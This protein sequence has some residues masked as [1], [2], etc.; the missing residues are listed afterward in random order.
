[1]DSFTGLNN[2]AATLLR[3]TSGA[4]VATIDGGD[5]V[6]SMYD[7]LVLDANAS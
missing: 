4:V 6:V 5:R 1:M 2:T 7:T 3:V